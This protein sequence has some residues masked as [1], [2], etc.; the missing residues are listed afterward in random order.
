MTSSVRYDIDFQR[1]LLWWSSKPLFRRLAPARPV[2]RILSGR[3][4]LVLG[5]QRSGTTLLFLILTSHPKITGLDEKFS[6]FD[7]P[8]WPVLAY[9]SLASRRT[10]YKLPTLTSSVDRVVGWLPNA[11]VLWMVRHP[12]AVVASM[13]TLRFADGRSWLERYGREE[14]SSLAREFGDAPQETEADDLVAVGAHIWKYKMRSMTRFIEKGMAVRSIRYEDL[15]DEPEQTLKPALTA[16]GLEWSDNLLEH[17]KFHG[18]ERHAGNSRGNVPIDRARKE[19]RAPL[20]PREKEIVA[21]VCA[22]AMTDFAYG[23]A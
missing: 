17:H 18:S 10:L 11:Q 5:S 13:R 20:S 4:C 22:A 23:K 14:L 8:P 6:G 1:K 9:N 7:L 19:A 16:L 21:G 15:V 3:A 2:S 12:Y